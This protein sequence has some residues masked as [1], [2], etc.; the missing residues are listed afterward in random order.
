MKLR[1][2]KYI[3]AS[4]CIL[5]I[6]L[7]CGGS[8][9]QNRFIALCGIVVAFLGAIFWIVFGRCPHCGKYL[10]RGNEKY[11]PSCGGKIDW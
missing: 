9:T 7:I 1:T 4:I 2:V 10:G 3:L 8:S 6:I 11:C 5:M